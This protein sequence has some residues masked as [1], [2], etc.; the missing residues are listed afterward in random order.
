MWNQWII[1]LAAAVL[2][3]ASAMPVAAQQCD[4]FEACTNNDMCSGG[5]CIGT[6]KTGGS[7]DDFNE[8]TINDTCTL[9]EDGIEIVCEGQPAP[10]N[11]SCGGGCGTCQQL[12]P[13]PG[14]PTLCSGNA[15]DNG[16]ACDIGNDFGKCFTGSCNIIGEGGFTIAFCNPVQKVCPDTD[17]NKCT[18]GC[19]FE[20]GRCEKNAPKCFPGCSACNPASGACEP[21]NV[22]AAC[23]DFNVCTAQSR[24]GEQGFC[25]AGTSTGPTLTPTLPDTGPTPTP[26]TPP[27]GGCIGDCSGDGTVAVNELISGVNIALGNA[28]LSTCPTFDISGD[29]TVAVNELIGA[30]NS[31]LNGCV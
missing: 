17:G 14:F 6:P 30:V 19:N 11:T 23:D 3:G 20:N 31:L 29:G 7:C 21:R 4:D 2:V 27:V 28:V 15:A 12:A 18:D 25:V 8:C 9:G 22:G 26:T 10:V 16:K 13:F 5:V 1:G 24:C